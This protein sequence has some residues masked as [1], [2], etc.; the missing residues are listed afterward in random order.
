MATICRVKYSEMSE[1]RP[2][3]R[4]SALFEYDHNCG[5]CVGVRDADQWFLRAMKSLSREMFE[6]LL[7]TA[8][9][10]PFAIPAA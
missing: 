5:R 4:I 2:L 8:T 1:T 10:A 6:P 3:A 9:Y 7:A